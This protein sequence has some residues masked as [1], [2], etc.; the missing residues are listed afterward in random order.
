MRAAC[1]RNYHLPDLINLTVYSEEQ[2][3]K[4]RSSSLCSFIY[5]MLRRHSLS[6]LIFVNRVCTYPRQLNF[7]RWRVSVDRHCGTCFILHFW[8][9]E[10]LGCP[11]FL[12]NYTSCSPTL[13][14]W[15]THSRSSARV[16]KLHTHTYNV[17]GLR[18]L[19]PSK[20][21]TQIN[22]LQLHI[23]LFSTN[24]HTSQYV[25]TII[26]V[27]FYTSLRSLLFIRLRW[28]YDGPG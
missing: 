9:L 28:R 23:L 26:M 20:M 27:C 22:G 25:V 7:V 8:R 13:R 10:L 6:L 5:P 4:L 3:H 11:N 15:F 2:A 18:I 24:V 19:D 14:P 17:T 12:E 21:V 16:T 1:S